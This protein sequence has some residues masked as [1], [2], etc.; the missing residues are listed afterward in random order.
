LTER[1]LLHMQAQLDNEEESEQLSDEK[2]GDAAK[3]HPHHRHNLLKDDDDELMYLEKHLSRVHKAFYDEYDS[4]RVSA[5]GG[6]VAQL[7][8]GHNKK[9]PIKEEA[10]DLKTVPDIGIVMPLLKYVFS[11]CCSAP[12]Y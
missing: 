3:Q 5:Q 10:A 1:P 4:T 2:N 8:P 6:R 7:K 9:I 11:L 12:F